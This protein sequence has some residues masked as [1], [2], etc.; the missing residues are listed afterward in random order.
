[1][2][3]SIGYELKFAEKYKDP[4]FNTVRVEPS[5]RMLKKGSLLKWIEMF[6]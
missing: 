2:M 5:Y 6:K 1:M 4:P 3:K